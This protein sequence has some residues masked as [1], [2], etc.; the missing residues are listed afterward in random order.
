MKKKS[1]MFS[2]IPDLKV[3]AIIRGCYGIGQIKKGKPAAKKNP[4]IHW[5]SVLILIGIL[6]LVLLVV[7]CAI[8]YGKR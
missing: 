1:S 2:R 7:L 3:L 8:F 6:S 4:S 5:Q